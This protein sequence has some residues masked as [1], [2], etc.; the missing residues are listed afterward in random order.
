MNAE[1][2][3]TAKKKIISDNIV[4]SKTTEDKVIKIQTPVT[5]SEDIK[6][7]SYADNKQTSESIKTPTITSTPQPS[8][9]TVKSPVPQSKES[10]A[11]QS[12]VKKTIDSKAV[13]KSANDHIESNDVSNDRLLSLAHRGEWTLLDHTLR[14][15]NTRPSAEQLN[16]C[17]SESGLNCLMLAV[18]DNR[19]VLC[20]RLLELGADANARA[21]VYK[22]FFFYI[23]STHMSTIY[24]NHKSKNVYILFNIIE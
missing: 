16:A 4:K 3:K 12:Q 18:R 6:K 22:H 14:N 10:H 23:I 13:D 7:T 8:K 15:M 5:K 17:E 21:L 1:E 24:L 2:D 11:Q 19:L 9:K 20:E